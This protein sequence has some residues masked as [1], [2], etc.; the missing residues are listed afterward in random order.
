VRDRDREAGGEVQGPQTR[1]DRR[2]DHGGVGADGGRESATALAEEFGVAR[3][4]VYNAKQRTE[5]GE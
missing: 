3:A 2:A 4:T 1:I 5:R